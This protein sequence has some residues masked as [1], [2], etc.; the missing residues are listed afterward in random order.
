MQNPPPEDRSSANWLQRQWDLIRH[1]HW[2]DVI[3]VKVEQGASNVAVGKYIL[4]VNVGGRNLAVPVIWIALSMVIVVAV[5]LYPIVK[6]LFWP[7]KM[8]GGALNVAIVDFGETRA[9]GR[10]RRSERGSLLSTWLY[11]ELQR[12]IDAE[13]DNT[14]LQGIDIWHNSRLGTPRD[15]RLGALQDEAAAA[16]LAGRIGAQMVIYGTV[17]STPEGEHLDIRFF[18]AAALPD[19]TNLLLGPHVLGRPLDL[20]MGVGQDVAANLVV[21]ERLQVRTRAL[22]SLVTGLTQQLLGRSEAALATFRQAEAAL[23]KWPD[24]AGKDILYFL[25]GR[26]ELFLG[27]IDRAE[28]AF[29]E[30][31][32]RNPDYARGQTALGSV[33]FVQAQGMSPQAR[34]EPPHPLEQAQ[35]RQQLAVRLAG[36][37][38][39][40]LVEALSRVA[41]AKTYRLEGETA[42]LMDQFDTARQYYKLVSDEAQRAMPTLTTMRQYRL[43]A[44]AYETQGAALLQDADILR[45]AGDPEGAKATLNLA[46]AAYLQC[47]AQGEADDLDQLL[48]E[49]IVDKF[50]RPNLETVDRLMAR[51]ENP[52]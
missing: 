41:L 20:P 31:V 36:E 17:A 50:C 22:T 38:E 51:L 4:Q 52:G 24:D 34:V 37:Q 48:D 23:D 6:P 30:A 21:I 2:R 46:R 8:Q 18:V 42:Y 14:F 28:E 43:L 47:I 19:E 15:I 9:D 39:N 45:L 35:E 29:L 32:N 44:Q 27:H 25:I 49:T 7:A 16:K 3:I 26:E 11:E 1:G 40:P 5:L 33:Y 10:V 12:T 13:P